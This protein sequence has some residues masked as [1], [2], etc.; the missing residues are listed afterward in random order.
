MAIIVDVLEVIVE[1]KPIFFNIWSVEIQ[2]C[3][4]SFSTMFSDI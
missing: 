3:M 1:S 2:F 4:Q